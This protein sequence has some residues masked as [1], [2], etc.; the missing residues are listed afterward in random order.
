MKQMLESRVRKLHNKVREVATLEE[1]K[2]KRK[3][4]KKAS[5]MRKRTK[6]WGHRHAKG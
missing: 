4:K 1:V 6:K 5:Q 2:K 3:K